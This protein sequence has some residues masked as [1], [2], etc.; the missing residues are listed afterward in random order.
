MCV[1][2]QLAGARLLLQ[3]QGQ[4]RP[5][6]QVLTFGAPLVFAHPAAVTRMDSDVEQGLR[7][8]VHN[9]VLSCD[10]IPRLLGKGISKLGVWGGEKGMSGAGS[11]Y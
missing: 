8:H 7:G 5:A 3:N 9:Y 2:S 11:M 4:V 10:I 6:V 1:C